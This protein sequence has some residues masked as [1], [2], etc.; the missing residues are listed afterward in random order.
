MIGIQRELLSSIEI[1]NLRE[2]VEKALSKFNSNISVS[3]DTY[4]KDV[5]N[6]K[7]TLASLDN[8]HAD[9]MNKL[10]SI[11][12]DGKSE[13]AYVIGTKM[14]TPEQMKI[15]GEKAT[16]MAN[17]FVKQREKYEKDD[18]IIFGINSFDLTEDAINFI[19]RLN[20]SFETGPDPNGEINDLYKITGL[21]VT[22]FIDKKGIIQEKKIGY[23][24]EET[25]QEWISKEI[26]T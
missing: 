16:K 8:N 22:I 21:P 23:I 19:N 14:K 5:S 13:T 18:L 2:D 9:K 15:D 25:L 6:R 20:V 12:Q 3:M 4:L 1:M 26:E 11:W 10:T 7:K 24:D 17:A